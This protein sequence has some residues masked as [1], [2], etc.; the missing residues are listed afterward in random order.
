M[1]AAIS[2]H[3]GMGRMNDMNKH[4]GKY[5]DKLPK[6]VKYVEDNLTNYRCIRCGSPILLEPEI[7]DYPYQCLTCD[8]NMYSFEVE[9]SGQEVTAEEIENIITYLTQQKG[10]DIKDV[11]TVITRKR[12]IELVRELLIS[13]DDHCDEF[14][15]KVDAILGS[16]ITVEELKLLGFD[17]MVAY[18]EDYKGKNE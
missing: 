11:G 6:S 10:L 7:A 3:S 2:L 18:I 14:T 1:I 15:V 16:G 13:I 12:A 8:E 4:L 17:Y 9:S 5:K